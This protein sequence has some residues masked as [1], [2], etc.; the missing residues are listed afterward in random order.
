[1]RSE[2]RVVSELSPFLL[3]GM[4]LEWLASGMSTLSRIRSQLAF[5]GELFGE[6]WQRNSKEISK[7]EST[8]RL[9]R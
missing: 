3:G 9:G 4:F 1:M 8:L 5:A 6:V 7:R 2:M